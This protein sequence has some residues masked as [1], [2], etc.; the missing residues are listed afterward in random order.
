MVAAAPFAIFFGLSAFLA[1][2]FYAFRDSI[3]AKLVANATS[4][5]V[6]IDRA[7]I[8]LKVEEV[9][10]AMFG[11]GALLWVGASIVIHH[12][13]LVALLMLPVCIAVAGVGSNL[14]LDF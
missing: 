11:G 6:R 12:P 2:G 14:W 4:F 8:A 10:L 3:I 5:K 1:L 7:D 13:L 9:I